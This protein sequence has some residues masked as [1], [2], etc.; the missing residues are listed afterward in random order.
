MM[1]LMLPT[2]HGCAGSA[3]ADVWC[4]TNEAR[5]PTEAEY[6][7]MDTASKAAMRTHNAYGAA[8]CGWKP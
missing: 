3:S 6:V 7:A 2:L 4:L 8:R 5:R 1:S